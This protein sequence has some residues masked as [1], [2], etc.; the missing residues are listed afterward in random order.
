MCVM[1]ALV[2]NYVLWLPVLYFLGLL[3]DY[4]DTCNGPYAL[5]CIEK[6]HRKMYII[7]IIII[8]KKRATEQQKYT[9]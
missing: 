3:Y 6:W 1:Y 4:I 5:S 9:G 2:H 8:T 7:I